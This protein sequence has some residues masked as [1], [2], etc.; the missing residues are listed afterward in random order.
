[1]RFAIAL[2]L[3]TALSSMSGLASA[4]TMSPAAQRTQLDEEVVVDR[5]AL[6]AMLVKNRAA[7]LAAFRAYQ[8][9]RVY[10]SNVY[11]DDELNVWRDKDGHLCAVATMVWK[12]GN[13][14]LVDRVADQN[15]FIKLADVQ[16]G[17]R[18]GLDLDVGVH[19]GGAR[20]RSRSPL[21]P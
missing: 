2:S 10:P 1:M 11:T 19:A 14:D 17:P 3:A 6:R 18:D 4:E 12:S 9:A 20:S 15:N 8:K 13:H 21:A 16:Q 5:E 7:N